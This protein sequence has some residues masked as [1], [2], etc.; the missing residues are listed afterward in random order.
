MLCGIFLPKSLSFKLGRA[1]D[2]E[3]RPL[4][5]GMSMPAWNCFLGGSRWLWSHFAPFVLNIRFL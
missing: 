3:E 4:V 1:V 5:A 2:E